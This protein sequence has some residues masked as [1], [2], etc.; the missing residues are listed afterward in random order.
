MAQ[1]SCLDRMDCYNPTSPL[2]EDGCGDDEAADD[3]NGVDLEC[4]D[5]P[6]VFDAEMDEG[7]NG[8]G[9]EMR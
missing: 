9:L 4:A 2:D 8:I 6:D 5:I 1:R 7:F 3:F